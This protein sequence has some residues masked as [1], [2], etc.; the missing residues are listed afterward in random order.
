MKRQNLNPVRAAILA[1]ILAMTSTIGFAQGTGMVPRPLH[2]QGQGGP[3]GNLRGEY[4]GPTP[5]AMH[6]C[7]ALKAGAN[8]TYVGPGGAPVQGSCSA[9]AGRPLA[10][11]TRYEALGR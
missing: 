2:E 7:Q 3:G 4:R 5:S 10:C 9:Q 8:C 6:A 1:V 11:Q